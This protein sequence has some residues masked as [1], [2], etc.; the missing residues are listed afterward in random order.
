M[1]TNRE[2]SG[3]LPAAQYEASTVD[4]LKW[5]MVQCIGRKQLDETRFGVTR[6]KSNFEWL[7]ALI[8]G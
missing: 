3:Y 7:L 2:R 4:I 5:S 1:I 6:Q 8:H